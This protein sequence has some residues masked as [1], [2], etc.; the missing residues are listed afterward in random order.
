M[1]NTPASPSNINQGAGAQASNLVND[2]KAKGQD[3]KDSAREMAT[4][5]AHKAESATTSVGDSL[6]S[7]ADGLREHAPQGGMIGRASGALADSLDSGGRYLQEEGLRGLGDDMTNVIRRYP[8]PSL[9][10]GIGL[11]FLIARATTRS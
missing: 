10:V 7:A 2:L 9:L 6:R 5:V 4:N 11:G 3:I 8:L 1:T